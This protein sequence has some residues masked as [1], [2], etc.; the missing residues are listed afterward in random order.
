MA[1]SPKAISSKLLFSSYSDYVH[2]A[3]YSSAYHY[4]LYL[5]QSHYSRRSQALE[6]SYISEA[7]CL[8]KSRLPALERKKTA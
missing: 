5:F 4:L 2:G 3:C 8:H 7:G 1:A 6:D